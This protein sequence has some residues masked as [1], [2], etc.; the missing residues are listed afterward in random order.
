MRRRALIAL[1]GGAAIAAPFAGRAQQTR[2]PAVGFLAITAPGPFAPSLAAFH[3]GLGE[4]GYVEGRNVA[5]E[6][7]WAD[8]RQDRLPALAADLVARKVDVIVTMGGVLAARAAK[9]ATSTIAIVFETGLDP[10]ASGLV[11]S[12]ARPGRNLT[13][14]A[15]LTAE[16]NPKRFELL[17]EVVPQARVIALLVNPR[18]ASADRVIA[19]VQKAGQAKG[20]EVQ[21]VTALAEADYEPAFSLARSKAGALLVGN[22]P[23]F[24]SRRSELVALAARHAIPAI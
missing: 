1:L 14:V 18:N 9:D 3:E 5:F 2:M 12:F 17:S 15:I 6:Y 11:A 24:F 19:E 8:G 22:D 13:G 16:L 20:V 10:V 4:T 23:V 21:V 7:R